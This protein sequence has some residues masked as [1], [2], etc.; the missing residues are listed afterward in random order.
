MEQKKHP[1]GDND[2]E[3]LLNTIQNTVKIVFL[4]ISLVSLFVLSYVT[5]KHNLTDAQMKIEKLE[6]KVDDLENRLR[7]IEKRLQ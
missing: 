5:I 2:I 3:S 1:N 4:V 6:K 7:E